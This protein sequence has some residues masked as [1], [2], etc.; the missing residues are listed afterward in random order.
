MLLVIAGSEDIVK[1][2]NTLIFKIT[3]LGRY[4]LHY[5]ESHWCNLR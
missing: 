3:L 4:Y 2:W 5:A 1:N